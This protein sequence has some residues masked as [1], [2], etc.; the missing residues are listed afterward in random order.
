L[1]D[2]RRRRDE[3]EALHDWL[4]SGDTPTRDR[5]ASVLPGREGFKT[6]VANTEVL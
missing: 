2:D 6:S 3:V 4:F 5:S 1:K